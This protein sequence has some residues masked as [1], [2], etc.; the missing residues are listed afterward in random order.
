LPLGL[1]LIGF[2][3]EDAGLFAGAGAVE[4]LWSR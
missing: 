1:Q 4:A 3:D 2:R